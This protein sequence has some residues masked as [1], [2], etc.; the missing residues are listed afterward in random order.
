MRTIDQSL[1]LMIEEAGCSQQLSGMVVLPAGSFLM[2]S[3]TGGEFETPVH[4]V[5]VQSFFM[6]ETPVTNGQFEEFVRSTGYRTGAE[7]AGAAWGYREGGFRQIAGLSWRRYAL[8]ERIDHPVVLVSWNDAD[9]YAQW[10]GKGLP[11]EAQWEYAARGGLVGKQYPWGDDTP[12]GTLCNFS[13]AP[14]EFPPT[15][16]TKV[17]PPNAFGLHDMVGNVWQ[18]CH[19]WYHAEAYAELAVCHAVGPSSGEFKARRGGAW[20]VIQAFRL[21][22]ANRGAMAPQACAP[23][24]GFRCVAKVRGDRLTESLPLSDTRSLSRTEEERRDPVVGP[25]G[26]SRLR[27]VAEVLAELRP[28]MQAD[29]GDVELVSVENGVICVSLHGTCHACPSSKLTL[30]NG[31]ERTLRDRLPWVLGVLRTGG[32]GD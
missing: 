17:Y 8:P 31:I 24:V 3:E 21:R 2:G 7:R 25:Q 4:E 20:N 15:T 16:S 18:W 11:T 6:D 32:G 12:D 13:R 29:G 9:S 28:A 23:N 26:A 22:A 30:K 19:D 1:S 10:A 5:S 14:E 27:E